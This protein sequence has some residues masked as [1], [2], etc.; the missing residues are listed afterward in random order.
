MGDSRADKEY[1]ALKL[2]FKAVDPQGF[3]SKC[4]CVECGLGRDCTDHPGGLTDEEN[5]R[6]GEEKRNA[7]K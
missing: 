1:E 7:S 4:G 5:L 3:W 6:L 2:W